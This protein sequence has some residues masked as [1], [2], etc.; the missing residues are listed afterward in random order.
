[1]STR[2]GCYEVPRRSVR[3]DRNRPDAAV[4]RVSTGERK[5]LAQGQSDSA[6]SLGAGQEEPARVHAYLDPQPACDTYPKPISVFLPGEDINR[7]SARRVFAFQGRHRASTAP[8]SPARPQPL[9]H[10]GRPEAPLMPN[11]RV[12]HGSTGSGPP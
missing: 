10:S 4:S 2:G 6:P 11:S 8:G 12:D 3:I 1:V 9:R 5:N 7:N